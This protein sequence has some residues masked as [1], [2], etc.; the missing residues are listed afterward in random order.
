MSEKKYYT[1]EK[2]VQILIALLKAH[3]IK[4][5]IVS[6]GS[7]N[8]PLVA[9]LQY[10]LYFQC[11]SC[12]DERS[13]AYMACGLAADSETP[14]LLSCT[15]ATASRNYLP[16]MTEAFYR[17][18]PI[19]AVT[20]THPIHWV[21]HHVA[22]VIDRSNQPNDT[23]SLSVTLPVIKDARDQEECGI[24]VNNAL[25]QIYRAAGGPSHIDLQTSSLQTYRTKVLPDV[26]KISHYND[27]GL[28]PDI[29]AAR[30]AIF[31]GSHRAF[32]EH[33]I[34]AIEEFC[35]AYNGVV[36]CDHTS[37][38]HGKYRILAP[39]V[40]AQHQMDLATI[41]PD[42][43][44]HLG[45]VSGDYYGTK[46]IGKDVWRVNNDGILRDTFGGLTKVFE[47][48]TRSFFDNYV[49]RREAREHDSNN[50]LSNSEYF[51]ACEQIQDGISSKMPELPFSNL[52]VASQLA[53]GIPRD[54]TI[55]F[56]ILNSLR[57][58][59]FFDLDRSIKTAANVGGFGIDGC[60]SSLLGASLNDCNNPYF[61]V[62]GDLAFF[63]DLNAIGNRH[64]RGN[65]RILLVNNGL[66]TEFK[67]Y[68]H[69][70]SHFGDSADEFI[71]AAG[72]FG[73][74]SRTLVRNLATDLGFDYL[75]ASSKEEFSKV[76]DRFLDG[77]TEGKPIIFE[78][79]TDSNEECNALEKIMNIE[80]DR[81]VK[82]KGILK[83]VAKDIVGDRGLS[84][85]RRMRQK[86]D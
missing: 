38:Y 4:K 78:V 14:V 16:G 12:V 54:S 36:F 50:G 21:G 39:L 18:L 84:V 46:L 72:H 65:I 11:F 33:E 23:Y 35:A 60:F 29:R 13:A 43:T 20:S 64:L 59:N 70:T 55:H 3:G 74:K 51:D 9:S 62:I 8:S 34:D 79:F 28:L 63:Y 24:K 2:N 73:R 10:D 25:L 32:N 15:G 40:G 86:K 67:T 56:G 68:K 47:M 53:G 71:C 82:S 80:V 76:S 66:G 75:C 26:R 57:S 41:K 31:I 37:Q 30:V 27:C 61:C 81:K 7:A 52:W 5:A 58:W 49:K 44:I 17:K 1:D 19:I 42:L 48:S 45:E 77:D 85:I 83:G 69:H 6:P 22:Q